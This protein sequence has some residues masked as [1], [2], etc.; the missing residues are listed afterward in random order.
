MSVRFLEN[1]MV[2]SDQSDGESEVAVVGPYLLHL[3]D[4]QSILDDFVPFMITRNTR[5][6][7]DCQDKG[8]E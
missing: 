5:H 2:I 3:L 7:Q 8:K 6:S 1:D 4:K